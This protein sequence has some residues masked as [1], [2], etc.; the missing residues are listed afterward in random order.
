MSDPCALARYQVISAYI[1]LPPPRGRRRIVL[2]QLAARTWPGPGGE[3]FTVSAETIRAWARRYR[4]GGIEALADAPRPSRGVTVLDA[5]EMAKL[6][7]LKRDVPERS[8]DRLIRIAEDLKLVKQG[9]L[10]R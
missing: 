6:C 5:D 7:A 10:R 1:A 3:P 9:K 8:L 4:V 2:E